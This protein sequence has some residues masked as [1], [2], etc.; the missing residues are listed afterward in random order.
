MSMFR[1]S[2]IV[3][4]GYLAAAL[5]GAQTDPKK[6]VTPP[7]QKKAPVPAAATAKKSEPAAAPTTE[8]VIPPASPDALFP[9]VVARVNGRAILGRDL[10]QRIQTQLAPMG[11]PKWTNLREE[12]RQELVEQSLGELV[13]AELIYQKA[14]ASGVKATDAEVTAEVTRVSKTFSSDGDLNLALASRGLDRAGLD[15]EL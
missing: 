1:L 4:A 2:A 11:N 13:G 9:A 15:R 7:T 14:V 8:E 6:P 10:E 12:Y 5:A 3:L